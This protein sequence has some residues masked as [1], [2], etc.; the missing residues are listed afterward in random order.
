MALKTAQV[1]QIS[2]RL[3]KER[4][5]LLTQTFQDHEADLRR[6]LR[7]RVANY[8]DR[9]DLIQD[10]FLRLAQQDDIENK[11]SFGPAKIRAYLMVIASNL[12]RDA[13]RRSITRKE[14][15]HNSAETIALTDR[16]PSPEKAAETK[17]TLAKLDA[18]MKAL[19][20]KCRMAFTMSRIQNISYKEIAHQ[21]NVSTSMVEKYIA[22]A[23]VAIRTEMI[24]QTE[25]KQI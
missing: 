5:G 23:L 8:S 3:F 10:V 7:A 18:V 13:H 14:S 24:L 19:E 2:D 6:F 22:K 11:L 20:P 25:Q 4:K 16:R 1:V 15:L 17:Q 21:M 9:D 12:V